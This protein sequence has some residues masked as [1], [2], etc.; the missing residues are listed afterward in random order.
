MERAAE[1]AEML[2]A[3]AAAAPQCA[4]MYLAQLEV[5]PDGGGGATGSGAAQG[6]DEGST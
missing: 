3:D 6:V 2:A 4:E 5:G 1:T